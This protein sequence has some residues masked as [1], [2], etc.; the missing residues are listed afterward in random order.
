MSSQGRRANHIL[1][2]LL[3][4]SNILWDAPFT[5]FLFLSYVKV[6]IAKFESKVQSKMGLSSHRRSFNAYH[7]RGT[8]PVC[9]TV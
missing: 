5:A 6:Y 3:F 4:S 2:A 9:S 1:Q 7:I 8:V